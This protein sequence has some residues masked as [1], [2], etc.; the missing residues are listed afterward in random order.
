MKTGRR[1]KCTRFGENVIWKRKKDIQ[2]KQEKE[3]KKEIKQSWTPPLTMNADT[4][5]GSE[6]VYIEEKRKTRA[7][8]VVTVD[9]HEEDGK[10]G[11]I[12]LW[13]ADSDGDSN[14]GDVDDDDDDDDDNGDDEKKEE[15]DDD[16]D[17]D[18]D[19]N[20]EF[21]RARGAPPS[22]GPFR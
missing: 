15:E 12:S 6:H 14:D 17:D 13:R 18:D 16:A 3:R 5:T 1:R 7:K 10:H 4:A 20:G 19:D 8:V 9:S 21:T 11:Q 2:K 22:T